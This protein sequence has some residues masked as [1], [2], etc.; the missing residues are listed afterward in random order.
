MSGNSLANTFA[1][2]S[3]RLMQMLD[4]VGVDYPPTV[5]DGVMIDPVEYEEM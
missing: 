4:Y 2:T 3:Q 5:R 1:E